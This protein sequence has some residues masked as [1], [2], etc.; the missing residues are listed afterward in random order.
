LEEADEDIL[1]IKEQITSFEE[2]L[3]HLQQVDEKL[4]MENSDIQS[5]V[6]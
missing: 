4:V 5:R 2:E 6:K 3:K 1:K